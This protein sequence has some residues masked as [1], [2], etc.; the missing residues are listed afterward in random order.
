MND[1]EKR[2][3]AL[4]KKIK[5]KEHDKDKLNKLKLVYNLKKKIDIMSH[6]YCKR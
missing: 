6:I 2:E 5:K 4:Y 3:N 1:H